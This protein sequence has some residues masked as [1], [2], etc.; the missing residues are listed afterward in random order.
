MHGAAGVDAD[1]SNA[2]RLLRF[3]SAADGSRRTRVLLDDLVR[4][5]DEGPAQIVT[6]E[7]NPLGLSFHYARPFLVSLDL[8]KGTDASK[9][10]TAVGDRKR[11]VRWPP[12]LRLR[13]RSPT[14]RSGDAPP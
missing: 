9:A 11:A 2:R 6:I 12:S 7:D 14:G 5:P 4:D 10:S 13:S 3:A 8:V 1:D